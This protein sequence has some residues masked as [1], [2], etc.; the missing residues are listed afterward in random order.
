MRKIK[1]G[2]VGL[3]NMGGG[4][5][6]NIVKAKF[7]LGVW[8]TSPKA[9][10]PFEGI[11]DVLIAPPGEMARVCAAIIFVVP[12]T[13]EIAACLGGKTGVL[14]NARPGLVLYDFTTSDPTATKALARRAARAGCAY[15]DA[16]MSGGAAGAAA[17]TLTLMMGGDPKALAR[18]RRYL[19]PFTAKIFHLG[20][21]GAGHTLKLIHNMV[22]HSI[23]M[24]TC[25]GG[26]MAER[27]GISLADMV[28][29]FN[30]AN[31]R[32]Y[33]SEV[34]FPRHILTQKWDARSRVY[35]LHKD[36]AMAVA[37]GKKLGAQ[38]SHGQA[39]LDFL[40]K[41]MA[42]GMSEKDY[43]LLYQD[44]EKVRKG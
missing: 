29:V 27:A 22:C 15:L 26:R 6:R 44:F 12:A 8:D 4:I 5:A 42:L 23:F 33:A 32:S 37:L 14:A 1:V 38:V 43:A 30:A 25:E 21:S 10:E 7:P 17:G 36:L 16:G 11:K 2:V 19:K 35:N 18:T 39:T 20:E 24:A 40:Q 3:G 13:P 28:E 34:R 31:A 41:A 9:L